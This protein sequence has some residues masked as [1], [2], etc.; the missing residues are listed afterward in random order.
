MPG[1][2]TSDN[3]S[4]SDSLVNVSVNVN[5]SSQSVIISKKKY[6]QYEVTIHAA[7]GRQWSILRRYNDFSKLHESVS[8]TITKS[9]FCLF[10]A[11]SKPSLV[12]ICL[13]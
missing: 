2:G 8:F 9:G 5:N 11:Q 7:N 3:S 12:D 6:T 13:R 1:H 4:S 10:I